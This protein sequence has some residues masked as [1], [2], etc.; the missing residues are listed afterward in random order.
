[1]MLVMRVDD[2]LVSARVP[3]NKALRRSA[4]L[5]AVM[6]MASC[7][8]PAQSQKPAAPKTKT[9]LAMAIDQ[10][11][12]QGHDAVLPP[13]VS[14]LLG[15]SPQER[16]VPVKQFVEMGALI[17]GFEVSTSE[18]NNVVIFVE[19][20]AKK[21]T[22]FY[23]TSRRGVLRRVLSVREGVGY[24]RVPNKADKDAFEK[25]KQDLVDKLVPKH[26]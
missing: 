19:D 12:E 2:P 1:M 22:T 25:E 17:R 10:T 16:E 18:H 9:R 26:P 21:E 3:G 23:L 14:N 15:I 11:L 7:W 24:R 6:L 20:R 8:L 5:F 4:S 13:H